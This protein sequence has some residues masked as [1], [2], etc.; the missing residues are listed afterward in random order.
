VNLRI[1]VRN[2]LHHWTL[3]TTSPGGKNAMIV[4]DSTIPASPIAFIRHATIMSVFAILVQSCR[5]SGRYRRQLNP[6]SIYLNKKLIIIP[7]E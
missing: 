4:A 2:R 3:Y 5:V 6:R 7:A 1:V